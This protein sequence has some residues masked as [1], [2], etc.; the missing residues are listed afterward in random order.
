MSWLPNTNA[1]IAPYNFWKMEWESNEQGSLIFINIMLSDS[2]RRKEKCNALPW[3]YVYFFKEKKVLTSLLHCSSKHTDSGFNKK[4]S[5]SEM[6]TIESR[7]RI[8][9]IV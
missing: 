5:E 4:H 7:I 8:S 2:F 9:R 3:R 1:T 6:R